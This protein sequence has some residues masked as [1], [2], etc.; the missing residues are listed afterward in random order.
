MKRCDEP[1]GC[2]TAG[3]W[4]I[5]IST[6][7][8][9]THNLFEILEPI[10]SRGFRHLEICSHPRHLD[11]ASPD[12]VQKASVRLQQLGLEPV[13]FHA[14]YGEHIDITS[15]DKTFRKQSIR[16]ILLALDAAAVLG[17]G[18]FVLH[19]GPEQGGPAQT[20]KERTE[21]LRTSTDS[22]GIIVEQCLKYGIT[23][24]LENMLPS[25]YVGTAEDLASILD[26]LGLD[27]PGVCL[28]TGHGHLSGGLRCVVDRLWPRL[29]V[30]HV[31]DNGGES[32]EHL[33]PG[34]GSIDWHALLHALLAAGY[35]G[36]LLLELQGGGPEDTE[37]MLDRIDTGA[38]YLHQAG[39][40]VHTAASAQTGGGPA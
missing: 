37:T 32:D 11:Y 24:V 26:R 33:P 22:I 30:L 36:P 39:Q 18:N 7:S 5:G 27:Q 17:A 9:Y 8:F 25:M 2:P 23:P 29:Q 1:Q 40:E 20:V 16:E 3:P 6:G 4:P 13:S 10:R 35:C 19:P 15:S 34:Q 28:D 12:R 21:K 31:H 38:E 14:P